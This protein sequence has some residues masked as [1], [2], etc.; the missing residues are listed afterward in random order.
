MNEDDF[1]KVRAEIEKPMTAFLNSLLNSVRVQFEEAEKRG[2]KEAVITMF[3][4]AAA[5]GVAY[6]WVRNLVMAESGEVG[7]ALLDEFVK[8]THRKLLGEATA[9]M[10]VEIKRG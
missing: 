1:K 4:A 9:R 8:D 5:M 7:R 3:A 6:E 2:D 10:A